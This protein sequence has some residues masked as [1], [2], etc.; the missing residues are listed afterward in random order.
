ML[1]GGIRQDADYAAG[2]NAE[3]AAETIPVFK[4]VAPGPSERR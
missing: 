1:G 2:A 3:T 4:P